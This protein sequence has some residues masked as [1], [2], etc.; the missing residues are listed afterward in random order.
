MIGNK[1]LEINPERINKAQ[2][3]MQ[4][5]QANDNESDEEDP[6]NYLK[7]GGRKP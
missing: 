2:A 1:K 4:R 3:L 5:F 7:M 6:A